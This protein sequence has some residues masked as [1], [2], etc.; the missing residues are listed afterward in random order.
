MSKQPSKA[1][2]IRRLTLELAAEKELRQI[3]I[4]RL[5]SE[6]G[7]EQTLRTSAQ[8]GLVPYVRSLEQ[9][10]KWLRQR[11]ATRAKLEP[12]LRELGLWEIKLG[13]DPDKDLTLSIVSPS[14]FRNRL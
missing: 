5:K 13:Y 7:M 3:D 8:R 10:D 6:I 11:P 14:N 9:F 12:I 2:Q 1:E 4:K